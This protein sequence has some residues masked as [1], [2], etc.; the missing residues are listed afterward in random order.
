MKFLQAQAEFNGVLAQ[1]GQTAEGGFRL[2]RELRQ[3]DRKQ[4]FVF[5]TRKGTLDDAISA[6]EDV[7]ALSVIHKPDPNVSEI[8]DGQIEKAYDRALQAQAELIAAKIDRAIYRSS[9]RVR[10]KVL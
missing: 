4:V 8:H 3:R 7:G 2:A 9:W 6:Y 10:T 1:L 5:F